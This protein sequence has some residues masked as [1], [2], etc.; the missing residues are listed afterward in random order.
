MRS[1]QSEGHTGQY[2]LYTKAGFDPCFS[3]LS[4]CFLEI[5]VWGIHNKNTIVCATPFRRIWIV[6]E[7]VRKKEKIRIGKSYEK[8]SE[9]L[10]FDKYKV[11]RWDTRKR[12]RIKRKDKKDEIVKRKREVVKG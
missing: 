6:Y 1:I 9:K 3:V 8:K 12:R 2:E 11:E 5:F 10:N 7:R 4:P